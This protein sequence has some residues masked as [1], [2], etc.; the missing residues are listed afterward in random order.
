M[1][2]GGVRFTGE[3]IAL[4]LASEF[5]STQIA[6]LAARSPVIAIGISNP[7]VAGVLAAG[8][9]AYL[10]ESFLADDVERL[11]DSVFGTEDVRIE[12]YDGSNLLGGAFYINNLDGTAMEGILGLLANVDQQGKLGAVS[13]QLNIKIYESDS[14]KETYGLINAKLFEVWPN[15]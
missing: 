1:F 4:G 13:N 2:V 3:Q 5:L 11:F 12:L 8:T 15:L 14:L 6:V 10:Y 7:F 9:V